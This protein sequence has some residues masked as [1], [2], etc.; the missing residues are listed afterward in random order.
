MDRNMIVIIVTAI[1]IGI[2]LVRGLLKKKQG[3]EITSTGESDVAQD[4]KEARSGRQ[5]PFMRLLKGDKGEGEEGVK[6]GTETK[7]GESENTGKTKYAPVEAYVYN[8]INGRCGPT[9]ISGETVA[10]IIEKY[11]TL[12]R[13]R[14]EGNGKSRYKFNKAK[15][16]YRPTFYP[17]SPDNSSTRLFRA[18]SHPEVE[19][20]Y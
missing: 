13:P 14:L 4:E 18:Q 8:D 7:G 15:S 10:A 2:F 5:N 9:V 1:V 3:K 11:G 17:Y 19:I 12:G 20:M 6:A 16:G